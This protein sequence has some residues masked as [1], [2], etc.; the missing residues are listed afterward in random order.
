MERKKLFK[1]FMN[2]LSTRFWK[3][4]QLRKEGM[5]SEDKWKIPKCLTFPHLR[6]VFGSLKQKSCGLPL[7]PNPELL[8]SLVADLC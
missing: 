8:L 4:R 6:Q 5:T 7:I 1:E 3:C 2:W